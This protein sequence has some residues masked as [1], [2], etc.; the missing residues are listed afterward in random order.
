MPPAHVVDLPGLAALRPK[1]RGALHAAG[2]PLVL[3]GG[4]V[5]ILSATT[6]RAAFAAVLFTSCS[7]L[8]L[9]TSAVYHLGTWSP[10]VHS[11]LS[12]TDHANI[13]LAMAGTFTPFVLLSLPGHL[14][15]WV[16]AATW[17]AALAG[18]ATRVFLP[19]TPRW[20]STGL[21]IV[22][23][24]AAVLIL[25]QIK[26]TAGATAVTLLVVGGVLYTAG[27]LVYATRWPDPAPRWFGFHEVFH[28]HTLAAMGCQF[29][30][31]FLV[32]SSA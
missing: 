17:T 13:Y 22:L 8:L 4:L 6:S 10:K 5:M 21:Y 20:A 28:A 16:L 26:A 32:C 18:A 2:F 14:A 23:G 12:R 19:R 9:G 11:V 27:A 1:L 25:P 30:A 3:A 29:A 15:T 31:V 7:A 24:W